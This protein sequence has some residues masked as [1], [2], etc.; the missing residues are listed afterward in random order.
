MSQ[1]SPPTSKF[2]DR[3]RKT[4]EEKG[5][6]QA[7]LA[8][9]SD[10]QPSAISHFEAGRRAPS[11][12]NLR[13]LADALGISTDYLLGREQRAGFAGPVADKLF[14]RAGEMTSRDLEILAEFAEALAK[15]NRGEGGH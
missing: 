14:R 13:A 10:L 5:M 6:S 1:S 11:F 4:R 8:G 9:K 12:D 2:H 3:L 15:K 7:Q